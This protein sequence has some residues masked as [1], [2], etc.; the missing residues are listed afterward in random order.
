MIY[1]HSLTI[2]VSAFVIPRLFMTGVGVCE[3]HISMYLD[4]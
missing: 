1:G 3:L 2:L 4:R